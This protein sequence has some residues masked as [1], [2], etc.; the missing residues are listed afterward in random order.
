MAWTTADL[1]AI[2]AAIASGEEEVRFSDRSVRYR[3]IADLLKARDVMKAAID[4]A[5]GSSDRIRNSYAISA[6]RS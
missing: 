4:S 1:E 6:P 5:S 3:S 2:E